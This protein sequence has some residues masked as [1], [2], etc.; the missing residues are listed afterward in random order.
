MLVHCTSESI[1]SNLFSSFILLPA[2]DAYCYP[3]AVPLPRQV[4]VLHLSRCKFYPSS[5]YHG[6]GNIVPFEL[7]YCQR[8]KGK[9]PDTQMTIATTGWRCHVITFLY[10]VIHTGVNFNSRQL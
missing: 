6:G 4:Y 10:T 5:V 8:G 1:V 9:T 2:A 7:K 3:L